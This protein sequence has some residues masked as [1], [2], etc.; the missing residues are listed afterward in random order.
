T[1]AVASDALV[2]LWPADESAAFSIKDHARNVRCLA[3]SADGKLLAGGGDEG[4][5][6]LRS[7]ATGK[8]AK[9]LG[10]HRGA[11]WAEAFAPDGQALAVGDAKGVK[12]WDPAGGAELPVKLAGLFPDGV[13]CLAYSPDGK[14]IACGVGSAVVIHDVRTGEAMVKLE[15]QHTGPVVALA[16]APDGRSLVSLGEDG[17]A[18][19]WD[20]AT[21]GARRAWLRGP[22]EPAPACCGFAPDGRH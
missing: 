12:F 15:G 14:R 6:R 21:P 19:F 7:A 17:Q 3:I 4:S 22:L 5:V 9:V 8:L 10:P 1:V 2:E 18:V 16:I 13:R 11:A 20:L